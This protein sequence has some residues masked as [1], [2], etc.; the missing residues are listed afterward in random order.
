[1]WQ[2]QKRCSMEYQVKNSRLA[3]VPTNRQQQSQESW[4]RIQEIQNEAAQR[5]L[6]ILRRVM[7]NEPR[8]DSMPI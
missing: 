3:T 5:E 1:M 4:K 7:N 2:K 6:D 8:R